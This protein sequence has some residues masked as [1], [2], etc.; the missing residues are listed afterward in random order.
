VD[1]QITAIVFFILRLVVLQLY[2]FDSGYSLVVI[3][4]DLLS[5]GREDQILHFFFPND[6]FPFFYYHKINLH[7]GISTFE[8]LFSLFSEI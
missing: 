6:S 4:K 1:V 2:S 5:G 3:G 7:V 8:Q